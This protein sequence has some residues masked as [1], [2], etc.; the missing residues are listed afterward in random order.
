MLV[1]GEYMIYLAIKNN[2]IIVHSD[3]IVMSKMDGI[4]TP[5]KTV[6]DEEWDSAGCLARIIDGTIFLGKTDAEKLAEAQQTVR[7][8]RNKILVDVVDPVQKILVWNDMTE[9]EQ[10]EWK[11]YRTALLNVPEQDIFSTDPDSV[12]WPTMPNQ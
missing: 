8:K 5:D 11:A 10:T 3:L 4:T 9:A 1:N 2:T 12:V 7:D 6:T